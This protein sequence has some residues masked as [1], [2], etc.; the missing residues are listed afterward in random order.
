MNATSHCQDYVF[1]EPHG[2][3]PA[4]RHFS[5]LLFSG[6]LRNTAV[7]LATLFGISVAAMWPE[8]SAA[9][10]S[11]PLAEIATLFWC[12]S[13]LRRVY[14]SYL[15]AVWFAFP[16]YRTQPPREHALK[17]AKELCGRDREQLQTLHD[18]DLLT[19]LLVLGLELSLYFHVPGFYPAQSEEYGPLHARLS[20]LVLNHLFLSFNMYW[21]HRLLHEVPWLWKHI[22]S[23]HHWA[24]HPL[25]RNTYEDH[26]LDNLGNAIVGHALAQLV[27]P[28]DNTTFWFSRLF[29]VMESL[30]KHS[31]V[32][33]HFNIAHSLQAWLPYA[34]M[35]HHHDW[36]HEG[37]K[38]CNYTFTAIGGVWDCLFGTRKIGRADRQARQWATPYDVRLMASTCFKWSQPKPTPAPAAAS[39]GVPD[40]ASHGERKQ[41]TRDPLE[42]LYWEHNSQMTVALVRHKQDQWL[43]FDHAEHTLWEAMQ[44]LDQSLIGRFQLAEAVRSKWPEHE[45]LH[46]VALIHDLGS[47]IARWGEEHA[48]I[49]CESFPVGCC[50]S[51]SCRFAEYF[52]SNPDEENLLYNTPN[53]IYEPRCGLENLE[54]S[55]GASEYMYQ[56]LKRMDCPIPCEGLDIVRYHS[57]AAWHT[58]RAYRHLASEYDEEVLRPWVQAFN[59][60]K[61]ASAKEELPVPDCNALWEEY[62]HPL[63]K[64]FGLSN[65]ISW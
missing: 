65:V 55:W 18:H 44:L 59:E 46:L 20:K 5:S 11:M 62:Y 28:L 64:R 25:S 17:K 41:A 57:F 37:H 16:C 61:S 6:S 42:Q 63:C 12:I 50:L 36:H 47:L 54:M 40:T 13:I 35:P 52:K 14:T 51:T 23:F 15:E 29:R 60:A 7:E 39:A 8:A 21:M 9:P 32:S 33:C 4:S 10:D 34:Q 3:L 45:W 24:R 31:G 53:G 19:M 26:C 2:E 56:L 38:G 22:H 30:E 43:E 58:R 1:N 49:A 48:S 27:V